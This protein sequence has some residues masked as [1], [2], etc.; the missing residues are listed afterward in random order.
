MGLARKNFDCEKECHNVAEVNAVMFA[1]KNQKFVTE[2]A[3]SISSLW[4]MWRGINA[5]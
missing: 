4:A 5:Y 1:Q 3:C 2:K